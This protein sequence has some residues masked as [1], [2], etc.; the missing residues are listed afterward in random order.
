MGCNQS[1]TA[2][3]YAVL[4]WGVIS[5][6][7]AKYDSPRMVRVCLDGGASIKQQQNGK[8]MIE[9]V[10]EQ[11]KRNRQA[12]RRSEADNCEKVAQMLEA[13]A[14]SLLAE[15]VSQGRLSDVQLISQKLRGDLHQSS[16]FGVL[17]LLSVALKST[18]C[19]LQLVQ[20]LV[21]NHPSNRAAVGL[22]VTSSNPPTP[23]H[24][25]TTDPATKQYLNGVLNQI[26]LE[27]PTTVPAGQGNEGASA[28]RLV[29]HVELL[30]TNGANPNITDEHGN[31]VLCATVL[32]GHVP[33][34]RRLLHLGVDSTYVNPSTGLS[35]LQLAES[36]SQRDPVLIAMLKGHSFN[37]QFQH[38]IKSMQ[39]QK[40]C[41]FDEWHSELQQL[42]TTGADIH[43]LNSNQET[44]LHLLVESLVK[45]DQED[46]LRFVKMFIA[47]FHADPEKMNI[48]GLR[49]VEVAILH[50]R[51]LRVL[52]EL[53]D[54]SNS[55]NSKL[56]TSVLAFA[57]NAPQSDHKDATIH[58]IQLFLNQKL[59]E[60]CSKSNRR[61][62]NHQQLNKDVAQLI[63]LGANIND[64]TGDDEHEGYTPLC[65]VAQQGDA[66]LVQQFISVH[67]AAPTIAAQGETSFN[68]SPLHLA[69]EAGQLASVHYLRSLQINMNVLNANG[70]TA[71]HLAARNG[72]VRVVK[73]L[74]L[75]G[76]N[77]AVKSVE[78]L[79]ALEVAQAASSSSPSAGKKE[80]QHALVIA[81]LER[82][83]TLPVC[84]EKAVVLMQANPELVDVC[85]PIVLQAPGALQP[86][87]PSDED[88][89]GEKS[90]GMIKGKPNDN[91]KAAA[92]KGNLQ[93]AKQAVSEGA[94][95]RHLFDGKCAWSLALAARD[96]AR[97][98]RD[99]AVKWEEKREYGY[100]ADACDQVADYLVEV[101]TTKLREAIE[102][103]VEPRVPAYHSV[104]ARLDGLV[105]LSAKSNPSA[106]I[107]HYLVSN[108]ESNF[109][110][111]YTGFDVPNSPYVVAKSKKFDDVAH[112]IQ[113]QLS[114]E[115]SRAVASNSL[116]HARECAEA[117][118]LADVV[119]ADN[120]GTA[121][122][123]GNVDLVRF[124][125]D[126]GAR[127]P[128]GR[129]PT[130]E[131]ID[132]DQTIGQE[133]KR[134]LR[135]RL[136]DRQLRVACSLGD[137]AKAQQA[138][139]QGADISATNWLGGT[140]LS[141]SLQFT[142][143]PALCHYLV[144]RGCTMLHSQ[145][146]V[147]SVVP[148][149][150]SAGHPSNNLLE[151][152][153]KQSLNVALFNSIMEGDL[154]T[155]GALCA[156]G[157][158]LN[159][160]DEAWNTLVHTAV[161]FQGLDAVKWLIE[162]GA[163]L[164]VPNAAGEYAITAATLKGDAASV[165][166]IV[167][168]N[169]GTKAL[170]NGAGKTALDLAKEAR[171][172]KLVQL[173]D[174]GNKDYPVTADDDVSQEPSQEY[175]ELIRA[176]GYGQLDAVKI[177]IEEKYASLARKTQIAADM[178][179]TA[180]AKNQA[181]VLRILVPHY[182]SLTSEVASDQTNDRL[183][184]AS[185]EQKAILQGFLTGLSGLIAGGEVALDPSDPATYQ[186]LF[187]NMGSK[188]ASQT[189]F[190][191]KN[192]GNPQELN[193]AATKE[194][195]D[196][197]SK[198]QKLEQE[199]RAM[200]ESKANL[201]KRL[202]AQEAQL[203][204]CKTAVAKKDCYKEIQEA[205]DQLNTLSSSVS[206]FLR[207]QEAVSKKKKTIESLKSQPN[208]LVTYST[209]ENR[210]QGL[211]LACK[212]ATAG[213]MSLNMTDQ[214]ETRMKIVNIVASLSEMLPVVGATLSKVVSV[215]VGGLV[216]HM[217]RSRQQ[218]EI[219]N[220]VT[221]GNIEELEKAASNAAALI[222]FYYS[223]QINSVGPSSAKKPQE[224]LENLSEYFL[225]FMIKALQGGQ[226]VP[227]MDLGMQ[228]FYSVVGADL[229]APQSLTDRLLGTPGDLS[230][231]MK[232][233][234]HKITL[235]ALIGSVGIMDAANKLY[236]PQ[237]KLLKEV[238]QMKKDFTPFYSVSYLSAFTTT[239]QVAYIIQR[240]G[241]I[242]A[243][244][245]DASLFLTSS[246]NLSSDD[247]KAL[248]LSVSAFQDDSG[249]GES[250]AVVP[251]GSPTSTGSAPVV[252]ESSALQIHS[253]LA[254]KGMVVSRAEVQELVQQM[255]T[256]KEVEIE[257]TIDTLR[258][259][260]NTKHAHY[261]TSIEAA[262]ETLT[263]ES[264]K[265]R[266]EHR[267]VQ[268]E[269]QRNVAKQLADQQSAFAKQQAQQN[270]AQE[271]K[272]QEM[273]AKY[274]ATL[275]AMAQ[276]MEQSYAQLQAS[277]AAA[278]AKIQSDAA[279]QIKAQ[280]DA[281]QAALAALTASA[282]AAQ[283]DA[284]AASATALKAE[285]AATT[286]LANSNIAAEKWAADL[287]ASK[288]A[289][290]ASLKASNEA[291]SKTIAEYKANLD[292]LKEAAKS[293][294][295]SAKESQAAAADTAKQMKE[296]REL[297]AKENASAKEMR[298][299]ELKALKEQA[300]KDGK[301]LLA[302]AKD[303]EKAASKATDEAKKAADESKRAADEAKKARS[304]AEN[305]KS[306][307]QKM[308]TKA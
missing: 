287:A 231:V 251:L 303:A 213:M 23:L 173:M 46:D 109:R 68:N 144:S 295:T 162:R 244:G 9:E 103:G 141:L 207:A 304:E 234:G 71:L 240:R 76:C 25:L 108:E 142:H 32:S 137:F 1:K 100:K 78:G 110:K 302:Q 26:L 10:R 190:L 88:P 171:F 218:Q 13:R 57:R 294:A 271:A 54:A 164:N 266:Q 86:S 265:M 179:R 122:Q 156:L 300:E 236:I 158:E 270:A 219:S 301:N 198:M 21:E 200:S 152:F 155:S 133:M 56:N 114:H 104:G 127:I 107:M 269:L 83:E 4:L 34:A 186:Q 44:P 280:A 72:H 191:A 222:T 217:D 243:E 154:T 22:A 174:P 106:G 128:S 229:L 289:F 119:G 163:P 97:R 182:K 102:Q 157:A 247:V 60:V 181:E 193:K 195:Q 263:T 228:L 212:S 138:H 169:A 159:A 38:K 177:F 27:L 254:S 267:A 82:C 189:E 180:E 94:D 199:M 48:Q 41:D 166:Y 14:S 197:A 160:V 305:A 253:Q 260:L 37:L 184:S 53:L 92:K 272:L 65:L 281:Q 221:L 36:Q 33:M 8:Y 227:G 40:E 298:E 161:A 258:E 262:T 115:L 16:A 151:G 58:L 274:E 214:G 136:L 187:V 55:F 30:I 130:V 147:A 264:E 3:E 99:R 70:E 116:S 117:G 282:A 261:Q 63:Q 90:R 252:A 96:D 242:P 226:V 20:Y 69:A 209:I 278:I 167:K 125:L 194:A 143:Q 296:L 79:T 15:A 285:A 204:A 93:D 233:T 145:D 297:T 124:L 176:A 75:W 95:V 11:E 255:Q 6:K 28:N 246:A 188:V 276:K 112:Y 279:A 17:G 140:A 245:Q 224:G 178:V 42:L 39:E 299:K 131:S 105:G 203:S 31:N 18:S 35:V 150:R 205:K 268:Q 123:H 275:Q 148:L 87:G 237:P 283:K 256:E 12:G 201:V 196:L 292:G 5:K 235:R 66:Y 153:L 113:A 118:G 175:E 49:P 101:A 220:I 91:L 215:G 239:Q 308:A 192:A 293:S 74:A 259:D 7:L 249:E 62:K 64:R 61:G 230:V 45:L 168:A 183:V 29:E 277:H 19:N 80:A 250:G 225:L 273:T 89:L 126:R 67:S 129:F 77:T 52:R 120:V 291:S 24:N 238:Q 51:N 210:L 132:H 288:A 73:F 206:L 43:C 241:L 216:T 84:S 286:T 111:L 248:A 170:K 165:E 284:T 149:S 211:F 135:Q 185:A 232:N 47:D 121:V 85:T 306:A 81:F 2:D 307:A 172:N 139:E 290:D 223:A 146:G 59:W 208:L 202:Q 50:D 134:L 98:S 257:T